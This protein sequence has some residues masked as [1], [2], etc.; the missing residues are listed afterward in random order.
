MFPMSLILSHGIML[1]VN[2][3]LLYQISPEVFCAKGLAMIISPRF[4]RGA[5]EEEDR[6]ASHSLTT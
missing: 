2:F 4:L 5:R 3:G 6:Y 1:A